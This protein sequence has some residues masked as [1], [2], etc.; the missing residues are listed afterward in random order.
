MC[1]K[2]SPADKLELINQTL[3]SISDL[4]VQI[5]K[6]IERKKRNR[7]VWMQKHEAWME[8]HRQWFQKHCSDPA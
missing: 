2:K 7:I 8:E 5:R 1:E 6:E 3:E 4:E